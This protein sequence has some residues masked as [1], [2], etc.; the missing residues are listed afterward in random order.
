MSA[1]NTTRE[2]KHTHHNFFF[3]D[4][5]VVVIQGKLDGIKTKYAEI[6]SISNTVLKSLERVLTLSTKLQQT[7]EELS[8]WLEP[9]E[10]EVNAFAAQ[11]PVGK[12]L[13]HAQSRQKVSFGFC[14]QF[15]SLQ[16]K[17]LLYL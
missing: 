7:H 17:K 11:E 2:A 1:Y 10:A 6:K 14:L 9:V 16:L 13:S 8:C 5:E 12:Q 15:F 4:D 3:V